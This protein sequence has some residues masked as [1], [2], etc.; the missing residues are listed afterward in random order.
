MHSPSLI[1]VAAA[2]LGRKLFGGRLR[3]I[4]RR[5][6]IDNLYTQVSALLEIRRL[7]GPDAPLGML[8]GWAISPDALLIVLNE[9]AART[10]ARVVEFGAGESTLAI[11]GFLKTAGG[12]SLTTVEHD[13]AF[14]AEVRRRANRAG[15]DDHVRIVHVP[16]R[17]FGPR[18]SLPAFSS[19]DLAALD[20]D[21]DVALVD[22]PPLALGE[23]ARSVPL[24]WCVRRLA[25]DRVVYLDDAFRPAE[26]RIVAESR[27]G[28]T[29]VTVRTLA[30]EKGLLEMRAAP[31]TGSV[32]GNGA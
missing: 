28:W 15:L 26:S 13:E 12:G 8:R 23:A 2:W 16:L 20:A 7:V 27:Q 3:N 22:G 31:G 17:G 1:E 30:T 5:S 18:L 19:Y 24:D 21:F 32:R 4:A 10:S 29:G 6:D 9:I 25:G 14:A 11:A